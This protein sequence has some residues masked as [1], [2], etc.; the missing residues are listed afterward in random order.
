MKYIKYSYLKDEFLDVYVDMIY[1][2]NYCDI[3][4]CPEYI[5]VVQLG[6]LKRDIITQLLGED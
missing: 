5:S 3:P 1:G 4:Q 2:L 6:K